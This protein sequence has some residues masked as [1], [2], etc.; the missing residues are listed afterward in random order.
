MSLQKVALISSLL[1][2]QSQQGHVSTASISQGGRHL[3]QTTGNNPGSQQQT[4]SSPTSSAPAPEAPVQLGTTPAAAGQKSG[5]FGSGPFNNKVY[6]QSKPSPVNSLGLKSGVQY[7]VTV[8]DIGVSGT[9][10]CA[11]PLHYLCMRIIFCSSTYWM[12][13]CTSLCL[14][15]H[16]ACY[17][18]MHI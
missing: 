13:S 7:V 12:H 16:A 2:M 8:S 6:S 11:H 18:N 4:P 15:G 1:P 9:V 14:R 17:P 3:L 10:R 5:Y